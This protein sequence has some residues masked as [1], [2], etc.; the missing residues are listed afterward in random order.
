M[1]LRPHTA[2][3]SALPQAELQSKI[4]HSQ[5]QMEG[6]EQQK[7]RMQEELMKLMRL[8]SNSNGCSPATQ[9]FPGASATHARVWAWVC[10]H[11]RAHTCALS[12]CD[13][14]VPAAPHAAPQSGGGGAVGRK[15]R[16]ESSG[17]GRGLCRS[18]H[19]IC[20]DN[21]VPWLLLDMG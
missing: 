3:V 21:P 6:M 15:S 2:A 5:L 16:N 17:C 7:Q 12:A 18:L 11:K 20:P 13:S 8:P 9:A 14:L 10:V 19:E 1:S 4:Q